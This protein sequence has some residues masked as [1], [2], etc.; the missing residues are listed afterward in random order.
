M[1]IPLR[2]PR[3]LDELDRR[4]AAERL[5]VQHDRYHVVRLALGGML[6]LDISAKLD[7]SRDCVQT[8]AYAYRDGG[9]E[10]ITPGRASG[11]PPKL[12]IEAQRQLIERFRQVTRLGV[13]GGLTVVV[14]H[15]SADC[16]R[17]SALS[18]SGGISR[19]SVPYSR[20]FTRIFSILLPIDRR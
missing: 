6:T 3:D 13:A 1:Q 4:I 15:T 19:C 7:R 9:I 10:A 12:P 16:T 5:A 14:V 11:R 8:W 2:D 17:R 20:S 18:T